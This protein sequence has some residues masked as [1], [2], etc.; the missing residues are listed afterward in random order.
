VSSSFWK[1]WRMLA[2]PVDEAGHDRRFENAFAFRDALE[3]VGEHRDVRKPLFEQ[4]PDPLGM[5]VEEPHRV[6]REDEHAD[7]GVW[8]FGQRPRSLDRTARA[9]CGR[10][11]AVRR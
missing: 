4:V 5:L 1:I 9:A 7:G 10:P 8:R 11:H 3:C 6:V 2:W